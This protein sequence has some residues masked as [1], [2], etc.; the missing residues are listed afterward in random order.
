MPSKIVLTGAP[1]TGKTTILNE[2]LA[3]DYFCMEE[4]SREII[5]E[6]E[7]NGNKRLFLS[8]PVLFSMKILEKRIAQYQQANK[9]NVCC[10][11]DRGLPDI[12]AYLNTINTPVDAVFEQANKNH[13]YDIVFVF[14]PWK[15]IYTMDNERFET[16]NEALKIH[17][18]I[19]AEYK[20]THK[21]IVIV[22]TGTPSERLDFIL[23]KCHA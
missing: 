15:E 23:K 10:F 8:E 20:K 3:K 9:N 16:Y 14:P 11:F 22:P 6:A 2:L 7:K 12:T 1:G 17:D 21:N 5:Q 13:L 4:V 19:V 18:A